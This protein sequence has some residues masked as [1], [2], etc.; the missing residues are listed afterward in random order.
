MPGVDEPVVEPTP[1]PEQPSSRITFRGFLRMLADFVEV[2]LLSALLYIGINAISARIRVDGSSMEPNLHNADLVLVSRL[3]YR[4][5]E[6]QRGEVI[7]FRYPLD[8]EQEYIKRIIGLPGDTIDIQGGQVY[9]NNQLL[10]EPY[11]KAPP[12]YADSW[13]VP[14]GTLFVLGDNRNNSNDSHSWYFL[15][16][17]LVI[18]KAV[19]VYWPLNEFG[20]IRHYALLPAA[21]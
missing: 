17:E 13:T 10:H 5:G 4:L 8:P 6:P 16:M 20:V 21:P 3:A 2:I 15:P 7:V 1:L 11:I 19:L 18:G 12:A 9:V 14:D